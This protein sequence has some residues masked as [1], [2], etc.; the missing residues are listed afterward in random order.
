MN[1]HLQYS[2][3]VDDSFVLNEHPSGIEQQVYRN[4]TD[5]TAN[6]TYGVIDYLSNL[7]GVGHALIIQ[8]LSV[9][10]TQAATD[11]LF[12]AQAMK[13]VLRQ[14]SL[15]NRS[16]KSFE[17]LVETSSVGATG[18]GATVIATRFYP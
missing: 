2:S 12:D 4:G 9:A 3:D 14:A 5:A 11:I 8:G 15:S 18:P 7:D 1:F 10:A 6:H 13:S 17:L 16:V